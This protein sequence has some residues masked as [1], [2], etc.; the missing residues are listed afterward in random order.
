MWRCLRSCQLEKSTLGT[1]M[2][3]CGEEP[4]SFLLVTNVPDGRARVREVELEASSSAA[5]PARKRL[6]RDERGDG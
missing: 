4:Y 6:G 3:F 5:L 2:D 1:C